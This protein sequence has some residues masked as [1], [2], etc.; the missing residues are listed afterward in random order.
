MAEAPVVNRFAAAPLYR[1]VCDRLE[2][3][4]DH[5]F[6]P[7]DRLPSEAE[8]AAEYGVN[9]L[10]VRRALAGLHQRGRIETRQGMGS[11]V[12]P[13]IVRYDVSPPQAASFT[14]A[15]REVGHDVQVRSLSVEHLVDPVLGPA[16]RHRGV[17]CVDGVAWSI[18]V[19]VLAAEFAHGW[20]G[21]RSLHRMLLET[22][23]IDTVR[24]RRT[25]AAEIADRDDA[26]LL[27]I[28]VGAPLLCVS[29]LNIDQHGNPVATVQHR[30]RG[31]RIQ[32]TVDLT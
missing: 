29:G 3:R 14:A 28:P 9:R 22:R 19:T 16:H 20:D 6:A 31:D 5:E 8:L 2:Q 11:F 10:T 23:G 32:F 15:M 26:A 13:P 4:L 25:F 17:R 12:A 1:Q 21:Q 7:G 18:T 27:S 24:A 30:F